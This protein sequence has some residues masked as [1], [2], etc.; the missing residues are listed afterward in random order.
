M[1]LSSKYFFKM[2]MT[3]RWQELK[4]NLCKSIERREFFGCTTSSAFKKECILGESLARANQAA[5][6]ESLGKTMRLA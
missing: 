6:S 1:G 5:E 3:L 2:A 4:T